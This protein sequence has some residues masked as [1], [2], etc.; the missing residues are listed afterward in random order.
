[1]SIHA[2][3]SYDLG[4]MHFITHK[5]LFTAGFYRGSSDLIAASLLKYRTV[6]LIVSGTEASEL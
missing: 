3:P 4:G 2:A 1:M 5:P 6:T